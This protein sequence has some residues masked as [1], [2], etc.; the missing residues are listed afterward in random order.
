MLRAMKPGTSIV[1]TVMW[2][3]RQSSR[4]TNEG[5]AVRVWATV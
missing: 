4:P 2:Q 3:R 5:P 1:F